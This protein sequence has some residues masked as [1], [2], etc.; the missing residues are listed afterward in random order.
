M[1]L[2]EKYSGK[3]VAVKGRRVVAAARTFGGLE[4]KM[5]RIRVNPEKVEIMQ[6]P[7]KDVVCVY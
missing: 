5:A 3:Y 2:Q 1:R 7:P 4:R 6:V